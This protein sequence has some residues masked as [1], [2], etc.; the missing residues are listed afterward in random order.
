MTD[1]RKAFEAEF[2][3]PNSVQWDDGAYKFK[4]FPTP[5][6]MAEVMEFSRIIGAW[7]GWQARGA[8]QEPVG[9]MGAEAFVALQ[10]GESPCINLRG[11]RARM[12]ER[13]N[14]ACGIFH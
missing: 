6:Q 4:H 7:Q 5:D 1:E 9:Y 3:I 13:R 10:G 2:P 14:R 11:T 12:R 8:Q